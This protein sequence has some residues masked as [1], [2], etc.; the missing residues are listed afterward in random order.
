MVRDK[1]LE[2]K[3]DNMHDW[4]KDI[5]EALF[6]C[7]LALSGSFARTVSDNL[8]KRKKREAFIALVISNGIIAGFCGLLILPLSRMFHLDQYWALFLAGMSG[9]MGGIFLTGLEEIAKKR[10]GIDAAPDT[11]DN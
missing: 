4:K 5:I 10:L 2:R 1:D 11:N 8:G 9:W 6:Y 3:A 7:G